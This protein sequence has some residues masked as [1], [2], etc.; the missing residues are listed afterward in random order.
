MSIFRRL[1]QKRPATAHLGVV[2]LIVFVSAWM[3]SGQSSLAQETDSFVEDQPQSLIHV[4][5]Q[6]IKS[7]LVTRNLTLYGRTE[8]DRT[9]T[10]TAEVS[11]QVI[12]I[13]AKRGSVVKK[14]ELIARLDKNDLPLQLAYAKVRL[15]QRKVEFD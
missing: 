9:A 3:L 1:T 6:A 4:R 14:G 5:T 11:G 13:L 12:E 15:K 2:T 8:P 10:V 7:E